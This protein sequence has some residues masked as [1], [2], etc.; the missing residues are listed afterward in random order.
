MARAD[1]TR[2][3]VIVLSRDRLGCLQSLLAWL[4]RA[5][6]RNVVLFDLNSTYPPLLDHL[7]SSPY[8][9][10]RLREN[11]GP[12]AAWD[13]PELRE[14]MQGGPF[15]VTDPDV[16]P[17]DDCPLDAV[18]RFHDYLQRYPAYPKVG[19]GLRID[20]LPDCYRHAGAVRNWESRFWKR[21]V[22]PGLYDA[23]I[24]TTFALYRPHLGFSTKALRTGPPYVAR[25]LPWYQDEA[26]LP[27][28]ERYYREHAD[29]RFGNWRGE[30]SESMRIYRIDNPLYRY[31]RKRMLGFRQSLIKRG[32]IRPASRIDG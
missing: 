6:L 21:E 20:D 11:S 29:G 22:E 12:W 24:D 26:S 13:H 14:T 32:W 23:P 4:E 27:E 3:P 5:G 19:F 18:E 28:D 8:P 16:L 9:V 15:V 17:D 31:V 2:L 7:A 10:V 30:L 1:L 25:H